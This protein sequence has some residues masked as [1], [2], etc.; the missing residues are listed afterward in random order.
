[1]G[2]WVVEA[3]RF[4][5]M[6]WQHLFGGDIGVGSAGSVCGV[7]TMTKYGCIYGAA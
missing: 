1:M 5:I 4:G 2:F 3:G 7:K 6:F